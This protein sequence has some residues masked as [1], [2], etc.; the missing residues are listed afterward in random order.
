M[1]L[2]GN[3]VLVSR[4]EEEK[5]EGKFQTVAV[6]DSFTYK[7]KVEQIGFGSDILHSGK[8]QVGNTILFTKNS[9]D[10]HEVEHEGQKMKVVNYEDILAVL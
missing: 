7:G 3:R 2:I 6:Q 5:E 1:E 10:T 8:L 4:I 9:P